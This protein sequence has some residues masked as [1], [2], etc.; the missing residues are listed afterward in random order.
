M[1]HELHRLTQ[2]YQ[3]KNEIKWLSTK[4]VVFE[5]Y[6]LPQSRRLQDKECKILAM[7]M[8]AYERGTGNAPV[9]NMHQHFKSYVTSA[10]E[11][12]LLT[13][14]THPVTAATH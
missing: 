12:P 14:R 9:K 13:L 11:L 6:W 10:D 2:V 5:Y 1:L 8:L 4:N 7:G 3:L